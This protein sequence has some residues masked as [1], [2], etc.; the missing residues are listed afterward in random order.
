MLRFVRDPVLLSSP[1]KRVA[2][3]NDVRVVA[4]DCSSTQGK[5][6]EVGL[7]TS[8]PI[9]RDTVVWARARQPKTSFMMIVVNPLRR[10]VWVW[11]C[12]TRNYARHHCCRWAVPL[13][14]VDA[15]IESFTRLFPSYGSSYGSSMALAVPETDSPAGSRGLGRRGC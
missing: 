1:L 6:A 14:H 12:D 10:I 13:I 2:R 3:E 9:E 7:V 8:T 4:A 5:A 11:S 15:N